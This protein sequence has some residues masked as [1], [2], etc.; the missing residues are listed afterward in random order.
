METIRI[1]VWEDINIYGITNMSID[2]ISEFDRNLKQKIFIFLDCLREEFQKQ[3]KEKPFTCTTP[4]I[5]SMQGVV[6]Y[7][8]TSIKTCHDGQEYYN[9]SKFGQFFADFASTYSHPKCPGNTNILVHLSLFS[10]Q[11]LI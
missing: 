6:M 4:W 10:E 5:Q 7:N 11:I 3:M 9:V 8:E 2:I 1:S